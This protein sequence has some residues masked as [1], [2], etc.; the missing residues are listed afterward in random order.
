V[1]FFTDKNEFLLILLLLD[2]LFLWWW[3]SFE[4]FNDTVKAVSVVEVRVIMYGEL[5]RMG[6]KMVLAYFK[7]CCIYIVGHI[8]W[9]PIQNSCSIFYFFIFSADIARCIWLPRN[10][11]D[12]WDLYLRFMSDEV[13]C[14]ISNVHYL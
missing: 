13:C 12:L 5:E 10:V 3:Q 4:F 1:W 14:S 6:V 7:V 8:I 9:T 2:G 11:P